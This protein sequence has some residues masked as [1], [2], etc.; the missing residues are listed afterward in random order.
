MKR[1][2]R[3]T[4]TRTATLALPLT[5]LA[6]LGAYALPAQY[7]RVVVNF[8]ILLVLALGLQSFTGTTGLISFGH[9]GFMGIGAY[10][11]AAL[12]IPTALKS[13]VMPDLPGWLLSVDL[14]W[15]SSTFLAAAV[16]AVIAAILGLALTRMHEAALPLATLGLLVVTYVIFENWE[17][18]TRG[19]L[20]L[21]GIPQ[22]TTMLLA[23]LTSIGSIACCMFLRECSLG[24]RLRATREDSTA[25]ESLGL[26]V[27]RLRWVAWI[28]SGFLMGIGGAVWAQYNLA[29]GP[30]QFYF[31]MTTT[32]LGMLVIGGLSS[33][34]GAVI[35]AAILSLV[36]EAMRHVETSTGVGGLTQ[37]AMAIVLLAVLYWRPD[38]LMGNR[39]VGGAWLSTTMKRLGHGHRG[40]VVRR[41]ADAEVGAGEVES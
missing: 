23:L 17:G 1:A 38:G 29:F 41:H 35:G 10:A 25:A 28:I 30:N 24:W 18:M 21:Y 19:P 20:G 15:L 39:E 36:T 22:N 5:A 12:T 9:V 27:I 16:T 3:V 14:G 7:G 37:I 2:L 6:V 31:T 11:A 8:L 26:N 40:A 4:L 32:L 33:V 13:S 34:S